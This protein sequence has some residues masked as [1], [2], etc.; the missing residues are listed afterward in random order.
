MS[1]LQNTASHAPSFYGD[2]GGGL[3]L[4]RYYDAF[5]KHW[6][7]VL[8]ACGV[9]LM[10]GIP[11]VFLRPATYLSQGK[12]LIVSQ[13]IPIELVRPTVTATAAARVQVI[14]QRVMTR[15]NLLGV[16]NKF[17]LF[18]NEK[19]W[20]R[21]PVRLSGTEAL[22]KMRE[23][24]KIKPV[25]LDIDKDGPKR[26]DNTIAFSVSFEH[27]DPELSA[28]VANELVTLI[29][30][31]DARTRTSRAA[32][33]TQFLTR[34]QKRLEG[35]IG[36]VDAQIAELKR[37][38]RD[39]VSGKSVE[40]LAMLKAD[41]QQK[42]ALYAPSHPALRP[43]QQQID[44]LEKLTA[45]SAEFT[46]SMDVYDRQHT[47]LQKNLDDIAEKLL[48][49]RRGETLERNQQS[50]RLEVIEQP[51][52]PTTPVKGNRMKFLVAVI[53]AAVA[54]GLGTTVF[55]EMMDQ[56]VRRTSDLARVID[57]DLIVSIPYISTKHEQRRARKRVA[58]GALTATT[59]AAVG[60][61][62]VHLFWM[63]LDQLWEKL[64]VRF[65][66]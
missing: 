12:I 32:E 47:A 2:D 63:P 36:S 46:A 26:R 53:G 28:R 44:A 7:L 65:M 20:L 54:A 15:D 49:A 22:D 40:Q 4:R 1:S 17:Q 25:E 64:L 11:I 50:E 34:E 66:G 19:N 24:A 23:R 62:V 42:A 3:D 55:T 43:L 5:K 18:T 45:Q 30:A 13:Q 57:I 59:L 48:I 29:L 38:N 27:E 21:Q 41:L 6:L 52:T 33:T 37:K 8:F 60:V 14:E 51:I 39:T 35:E 9:I 10:I 61:A 16:V 31:E 56:S 58:G